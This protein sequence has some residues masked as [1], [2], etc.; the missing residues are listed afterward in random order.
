M[1]HTSYLASRVKP[2][3]C[4]DATAAD[5]SSIIT[6]P[7]LL[8]PLCGRSYPTHLLL[9][10]TGPRA[11]A[12]HLSSSSIFLECRHIR[13]DLCGVD[14][15]RGPNTSRARGAPDIGGPCL[16][17]QRSI[18]PE[19]RTNYEIRRLAGSGQIDIATATG[20]S[21]TGKASKMRKY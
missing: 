12:W 9:L 15:W 1:Q 18:G 20:E 10:S 2:S 13:A 14:K 5:Y 11:S 6:L 3:V 21:D 4:L 19:P 8:T 17:P 7:T 16:R